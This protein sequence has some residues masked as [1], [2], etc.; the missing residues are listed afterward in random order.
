MEWILEKLKTKTVGIAGC[1][2][3]GSNCA[4]S[5]A[6]AGVGRLVLADFDVVSPPNLNRQY[7]FADQLGK[8]KIHAL[9]ENILR[10][11]NGIKVNTLDIRLCSND[12]IEVFGDCDV[13][14]EAFDQARMKQ[15]IIETVM[16]QMPDKY[17]VAGLGIAGWGNNEGLKTFRNGKLIICGDME[18]EISESLPPFGPKVALVANMQANVVIEILLGRLPGSQS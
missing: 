6:R 3:L 4:M 5:L 18:N 11:N 15:M 14:V 16:T 12:V 8:L 7:F 10:V 2:G 17:L 1:G 9:K 13:I